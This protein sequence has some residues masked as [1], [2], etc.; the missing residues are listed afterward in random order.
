M[1]E[2]RQAPE[3]DKRLEASAARRRKA[4]I[5]DPHVVLDEVNWLPFSQRHY[6]RKLQLVKQRAA[7]RVPTVADLTDQDLRDTAVTWLARAG[8]TIPEI[9]AITGHS[10]QSATRILRHYIDLTGDM[11][12]TAIDRMAKWYAEAMGD[13]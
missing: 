3:L 7:K 4:N 6:H 2:I 12:D 11:A 8:C 9:C 1:L 5:V 13:D 10:L